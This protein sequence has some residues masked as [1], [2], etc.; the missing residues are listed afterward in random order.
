LRCKKGGSQTSPR[1]KELLV[2]RGEEELLCV[3][4]A[5]RP[6]AIFGVA[7][8]CQ[9]CSP[10]CDLRRAADCDVGRSHLRR[11]AQRYGLFWICVSI[12]RLPFISQKVATHVCTR[13]EVNTRDQ[14]AR[15]LPGR[16]LA[17]RKVSTSGVLDPLVGPRKSILRGSERSNFR[18]PFLNLSAAQAPGDGEL[19]RWKRTNRC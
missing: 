7:V 1:S 8:S 15:S 2:F 6:R 17:S 16:S 10:I 4:R 12:F 18:W 13:G 9:T 14:R 5:A 11:L 19:V 3:G